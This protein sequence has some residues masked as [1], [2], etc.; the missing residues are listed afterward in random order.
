[1]LDSA[2]ISCSAHDIMHEVGRATVANTATS[3][4]SMCGH[5]YMMTPGE[6]LVGCTGAFSPLQ[7][8]WNIVATWVAAYFT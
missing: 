4:S 5:V 2:N 6:I 3:L 1:M 7:M 8:H